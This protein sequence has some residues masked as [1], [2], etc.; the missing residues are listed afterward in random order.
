[1]PPERGLVTNVLQKNRFTIPQYGHLIQDSIDEQPQNNWL[2]TLLASHYW[3][4]LGQAKEAI[5]CLRKS[6]FSAP[7]NY[8]H[9][10]LLSLANIFHR[11]QNSH[12][13]IETLELALKYAPDNPAI[14][15]TMGNV[16][17]TLLQ[18]NR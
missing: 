10:P 15:F 6:I 1:M 3:R 8:K 5:E 7:V 12:D 16:Y 13:A 4:I 17:A 14:Y 2:A 18:F 9:L 11:S